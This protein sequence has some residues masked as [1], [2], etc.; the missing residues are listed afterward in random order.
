[1][2][3]LEPEGDVHVTPRYLAGAT[4]AADPGL[5]PALDAGWQISHD[6]LGNAYVCP[7]DQKVRIGFIPEGEDDALWKIA[8]HRQF[9]A[10]SWAAAFNDRTPEE[11]VGAFT[12]DLLDA[13]QQG[14]HEYLGQA[15][16][17]YEVPRRTFSPLLDA[18]WTVTRD[19]QATLEL[20]APDH[21]ATAWY[22]RR[23]LDPA[24]ELTTNATRWGITAGGQRAGWYAVF[25]SG[26]PTRFVTATAASVADP[27]PLLRWRDYLNRADLHHVQL[28]PVRPPAPTPLDIASTHRRPAPALNTN[29]VRWTTSTPSARLPTPPRAARR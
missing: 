8:A 14:E 6:D 2:R 3:D 26:T 5:R 10:P 7:P 17:S 27:A 25:S 12:A 23:D 15:L 11:I 20:T 19:S 16:G 9:T 18:G 29:P 13:Y 1:M 24:A 28:T 4:G 22:D 21:L